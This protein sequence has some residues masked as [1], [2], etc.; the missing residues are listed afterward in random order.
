MRPLFVRQVERALSEKVGILPHVG[1]L[2][3]PPTKKQL[4]NLMRF[5][6]GFPEGRAFS[7]GI[8]ITNAYYITNNAT[9]TFRT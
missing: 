2:Q 9:H 5:L 1:T 4:E 8:D 6:S 3:Y 7:G